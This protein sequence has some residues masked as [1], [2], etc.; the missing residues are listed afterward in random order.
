MRE[1]SGHHS[2]WTV[3]C[4]ICNHTIILDNIIKN[5]YIIQ[6]R[7]ICSR[8]QRMEPELLNLKIEERMLLNV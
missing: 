3:G 8:C 1:V 5:D 4:F 2:I 6:D 7:Y